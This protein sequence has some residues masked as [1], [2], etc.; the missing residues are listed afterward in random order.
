[1]VLKEHSNFLLHLF[2]LIGIAPPLVSPTKALDLPRWQS[3]KKFIPLFLTAS[4][5]L[6][7]TIFLLIFPHLKQLGALHKIINFSYIWSLFFTIFSANFQCYNY[8]AV[9]RRVN[10]RIRKIQ[11]FYRERSVTR[12]VQMF[13]SRYKLKI[14]VIFILYLGSQGF[15]FILVWIQSDHSNLWSSLVSSIVTSLLRILYPMFV[16]HIV[17]YSDILG[18]FIRNLRFQ[19]QNASLCSSSSGKI[20]FLK[21]VKSMHMELSKLSADVNSYFGVNLL[22]LM[23]NSFIYISYQLYWLFLSLQ[24]KWGML[25]IAGEFCFVFICRYSLFISSKNFAEIYRWVGVIVVWNW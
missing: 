21:S 15:V 17:L 18:L 10:F 25:A 5:S 4:L 8:V 16:L 24:L 1:M 23:I 22:F 2:F 7:L 13:Q 6:G 19:V 3:I 20:E 11:K 12:S 9:Y 14:L